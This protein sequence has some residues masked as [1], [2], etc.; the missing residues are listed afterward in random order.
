MGLANLQ[1]VLVHKINVLLH[2]FNWP[3]GEYVRLV[4][5]TEC[6]T[7]PRTVAGDSNEKTLSFTGRTYRTLFKALVAFWSVR[8]TCQCQTTSLS[9]QIPLHTWKKLPKLIPRRLAGCLAAHAGMPVICS[10]A[11]LE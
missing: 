2:I 7:I 6:T 8:C 11:F 1:Q 10:S 5:G 3:L 4:N 9:S